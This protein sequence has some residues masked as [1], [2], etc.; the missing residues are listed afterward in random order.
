MEPAMRVLVISHM[1]PNDRTPV[2]GSFIADQVAALR[3]AGVEITV[4]NA[5]PWVPPLAKRVST[6]YRYMSEQSTKPRELHGVRIE[7]AAYAAAPRNFLFWL[8]GPTLARSLAKRPY[9]SN[10]R[11]SF[12]LVHAHVVLPDGYGAAKWAKQQAIPVIC[13]AHGD[14]INIDPHFS[15]LTCAQAKWTIRSVDAMV[16]VSSAMRDRMYQLATP[17][18]VRVIPNGVNLQ[19]FKY[20]DRDLARQRTGL[21]SDTPVVL[22]VG[23]LLPVK[24]VH[25]LIAAFRRVH[26]LVP[27]ALLVLVGEGPLQRELE[28]SAAD[29]GIAAV[30]R[31]A[32]PQ[33]REFIPTWMAAADLLVLPSVNE[34]MPLVVL[35]AMASGLPVVASDVGGIAEALGDPPAGLLAPPSDEARLSDALTNLLCNPELRREMGARGRNRSQA[36]TW[37]VNAHSTIALYQDVLSSSSQMPLQR[38]MSVRDL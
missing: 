12:D 7:P 21:P 8:G 2:F 26:E 14:D 18:C 35:E 23:A 31:F 1:Y 30:V 9:L 36:L 4:I 17:K 15:W 34:G 5:N 16:A 19:L 33:D 10:A 13:T 27:N 25:C 11:Y 6:R 37:T 20:I 24:N 28:V 22:F 32:G 29:K 38:Q 3:E